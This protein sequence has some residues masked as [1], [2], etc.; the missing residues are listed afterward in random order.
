MRR[1]QVEQHDLLQFGAHGGMRFAR[2]GDDRNVVE[3]FQLC[4][5]I[6]A[7]QRGPC[8]RLD[9]DI[10]QMAQLEAH[11]GCAQ[12]SR[13]R[14]RHFSL[15]VLRALLAMLEIGDASG[16]AFCQPLPVLAQ[17]VPDFARRAVLLVNFREKLIEQRAGMYCG[18]LVKQARHRQPVVAGKAGGIPDRSDPVR[19]LLQGFER[20]AFGQIGKNFLRGLRVA[21]RMIW[22]AAKML[23]PIEHARAPAQ[24][25]PPSGGVAAARD[26]LFGPGAFIP[27][28]GAPGNGPGVRSWRRPNRAASPTPHP[29]R[30]CP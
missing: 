19:E 26:R 2:M 28:S 8:L 4:N 15:Y 6:Q 12:R 18:R 16:V 14:E 5:R 3:L 27:G 21:Q 1:S 17:R 24:S 7:V 20:H 9:A 13:Q 23:D 29:C 30:G 11:A 10:A 22:F 25:V